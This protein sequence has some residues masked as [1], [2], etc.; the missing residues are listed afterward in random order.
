[1]HVNLVNCIALPF[2]LL[3]EYFKK[4]TIFLHFEQFCF[5]TS[6]DPTLINKP[7]VFFNLKYKNPDMSMREKLLNELTK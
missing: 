6:S 1:M 2:C 5:C 7:K 3:F 4:K